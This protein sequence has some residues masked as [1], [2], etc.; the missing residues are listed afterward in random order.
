[1]KVEL[2]RRSLGSLNCG[3][4][5]LTQ[6]HYEAILESAGQNIS[7]RQIE[8]PGG[9][10]VRREYGKLI[11]SSPK[12][13]VGQAPPCESSS[14]ELEVPGR[15][16]FAALL[17]EANILEA[18][19]AGL[20]QFAADRNGY[21]ERFDLDRLK[22][23]LVLR[24]RRAGDRFIPLGMT[25]EKKLGKFLTDRRIGRSAR[26]RVLVVEDNEKIIW[27]WPIRM[28]EQAKVIPETKR[29]LQLRITGR[30]SR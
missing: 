21:I 6:L 7:G 14:I 23:P 24:R 10:A 8:L 28:S 3:E 19:S 11:F 9:F 20:E 22:P 27:L 17:I 13:V 26:E 25:G 16:E 5:D 29:I 1:V 30:R 12:A 18:D 4:R 2:I 15:V